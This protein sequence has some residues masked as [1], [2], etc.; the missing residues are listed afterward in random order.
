MN[1]SKELTSLIRDFEVFLA[2]IT[3]NPT[4]TVE[5]LRIFYK[6]HEYLTGI[7]ENQSEDKIEKLAKALSKSIMSQV[8]TDKNIQKTQDLREEIEKLNQEK[9]LIVAEI[10]QLKQIKAQ[11]IGNLINVSA[12]SVDKTNTYSNLPNNSLQREAFPKKIKNLTDLITVVDISPQSQPDSW[13]L[14]LDFG[15]LGIAAVLFNVTTQEKYPLSWSL[16]DSENI[17]QSPFR[18]P[19]LV[20]QSSSG[21]YWYLGGLYE[22]EANDLVINNYKANLNCLIANQETLPPFNKLQEVVKKIVSQIHNAEVR[23][24]PLPF[25]RQAI[26]KLRGIIVNSPEGWSDTYRFNLREAILASHLVSDSAQ[27][28]CLEDTIAL[29]LGRFEEKNDLQS[30][31]SLII[32]GGNSTTEIALVNLPENWQNLE[33]DNFRI[34]T[35]NYAQHSLEQDIFTKFIYPIEEGHSIP[36]I[37]HL[38]PQPGRIETDKRI[39]L[40]RYLYS[41]PLGYCFLEAAKLISLMLQQQTEFQASLGANDYH[42]KQEDLEHHVIQPCLVNIARVISKLCQQ[43]NVASSEIKQVI[44][45]GGLVFSIHNSLQNWL[46]QQF[47]HSRVIFDTQAENALRVAQGLAYLPY[48]PNVMDRNRHQYHDYFLL[49]ELLKVLPD[50]PFSL[51]DLFKT[52]ANRGINTKSCAQRLVKLLKGKLPPGILTTRSQD[53]PKS[54]IIRQSQRI[55]QTNLPLVEDVEKSLHKILSESREQFSEPL[56]VNFDPVE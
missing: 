32:N 8:E 13:Y 11:I 4:V 51:D 48:F 36:L 24:L 25:F 2:Q 12:V 54:L 45:G 29:L 33:Y 22:P 15:S 31:Y 50:N 40:D 27:I 55:Y 37:P 26:A 44:C 43:Q 10:D 19:S 41:Y 21:E 7:Q 49:I 17:F 56:V 5:H 30:G 34:A 18:F 23:D 9:T 16:R 46:T 53:S 47:P 20:Y 14:G 28:F 3:T 1:S 6:L 52:L 39:Q 42:V 38:L 35:L